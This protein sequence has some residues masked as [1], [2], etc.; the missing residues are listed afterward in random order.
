MIRRT[1]GGIAAAVAICMSGS[2]GEALADSWTATG[3]L[4]VGRTQSHTLTT[5]ADGRVLIAGGLMSGAVTATAT[6]ELYDP[7][8]NSW[9]ATGSMTVPRSR[10]IAVPLTDGRVLV[11][12]GIAN[13]LDGSSPVTPSA[14][15]YDPST[16]TWAPT[17]SMTEPRR[18]FPAVRLP[19]G[20]VF[21][22][23]GATNAIPDTTKSAEIYDPATGRWIAVAPM[24]ERRF[25]HEMTLLPDGR[26]LATGGGFPGHCTSLATAEAY[27]P[28]ADRWRRFDSMSTPRAVH[29]L[30]TL[31]DGEV[32]A[33][34]G[35]TQPIEE[36][37]SDGVIR[38]ATESSERIAAS[39]WVATGPLASRRAAGGLAPVAGGQLLYAGGR[40][41]TGEGSVRSARAEVYDSLVHA[42][43]QAAPL[44]TPRSGLRAAGLADGHVLV[45]GGTTSAGKALVGEVYTP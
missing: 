42:W 23:G 20:R 18:N 19:D 9:T 7:A 10:H 5:L 8:T 11:A 29:V 36:C 37:L 34:G 15:I 27:D 31:P 43:I 40:D 24:A 38:N 26:V 44:S 41:A 6:A 3:P 16:E 45:A 14:E 21:V 30:A 2:T 13:L 1:F 33:A 35:W 4:A 12:G 39:K 25:N 17:G 32:V 22:S 28:S